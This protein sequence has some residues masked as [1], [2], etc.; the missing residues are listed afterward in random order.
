VS[1]LSPKSPLDGFSQKWDGL[2]L[3]EKHIG[4]AVSF[5]AALDQEKAFDTGFEKTFGTS[6][7]LPLQAKQIEGGWAAWLGVNQYMLLLNGENSRAD[8]ELAA[9]FGDCAYATLQTD[10]WALL[11]FTGDR[12]IDALE[13][14]IPLDLRRAPKN[15]AART[16]AHHIAVIVIKFDDDKYQL[17]TPRSSAQSFADSLAHVIDNVVNFNQESS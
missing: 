12:A 10:G 13:R 9:Q 14:F 16:S 4:E 7:P 6:L 5:A 8:E 17:M 2:T 1:K 3:E 11:D 15:F